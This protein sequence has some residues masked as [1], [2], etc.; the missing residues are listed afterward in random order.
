MRPLI[1]TFGRSGGN[2]EIKFGGGCSGNNKGTNM[3]LS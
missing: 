3:R 1:G 2:S